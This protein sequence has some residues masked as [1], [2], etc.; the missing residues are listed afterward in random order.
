MT[1]RSSVLATQ[2]AEPALFA[3][4]VDDA[5]VFPPGNAPLDEAV[6]LH[7]LHRA[8]RYAACVGPLLVPTSAADQL[9]VLVA[10]QDRPLRIA[11]IARPGV[12]A[13]EVEDAVRRLGAAPL[14]DVVGV[15]LGWTPDWR[16]RDLDGLPS[17]LE[18]PRGEAQPGVLADLASG[19]SA[20]VAVQAKFRTG[21]TPTW[22]WPDESELATFLHAA[23]GLG[24]AFKLTGGLHHA[25]RDTHGVEEQH[26]L[27]NVLLAVQGALRGEDVDQLATVLATRDLQTLVPA[28]GQLDAAEA[29][30]IRGHFTAYGCCGVTDPIGE[31][32][33]LRLIE[34]A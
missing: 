31:L 17:T 8:S 26:G 7:R 18:V 4:L 10:G 19:P 6:R 34:G 22:P 33:D 20:G 23:T 28:V 9:A 2:P 24:L 11:V 21:A 15:E 14:V 16:D 29:A 27:L 32:T 3:G 5:A 25:V 13:A 1:S 30:S 12:P